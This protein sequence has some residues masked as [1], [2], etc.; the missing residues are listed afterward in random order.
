MEYNPGEKVIG[1][2]TFHPTNTAIPHP[3]LTISTTARIAPRLLPDKIFTGIYRQHPGHNTYLSI[4]TC[5]SQSLS[6][7]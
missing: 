3:I 5:P 7:S 2:C 6:L 4:P 1:K